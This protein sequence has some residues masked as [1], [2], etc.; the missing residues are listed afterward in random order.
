MG[1]PLKNANSP[2]SNFSY[3]LFVFY[4]NMIQHSPHFFCSIADKVIS[5]NTANINI[6]ALLG[7]LTADREV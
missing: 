5:L 2:N 3:L 4:K 7:S 6:L 1:Q